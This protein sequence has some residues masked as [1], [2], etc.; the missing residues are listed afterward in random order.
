MGDGKH[1][2]EIDII[3]PV[4]VTMSTSTVGFAAGVVDGTGV[5]LGD[6]HDAN[7]LML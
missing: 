1:E 3:Y 2:I 7:E 5:H 6:G 4:S